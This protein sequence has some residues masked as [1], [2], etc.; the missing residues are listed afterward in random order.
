MGPDYVATQDYNT[1]LQ[2]IYDVVLVLIIV[3]KLHTIAL[4]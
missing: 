4:L 1:C 2:H 3:Q